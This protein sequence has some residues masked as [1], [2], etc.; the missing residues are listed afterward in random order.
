[1]THINFKKPSGKTDRRRTQVD[2]LANKISDLT[3]SQEADLLKLAF[4][5][6]YFAGDTCLLVIT[7]DASLKSCG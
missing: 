7:A 6:K 4:S 2:K 5:L 1:M 3:V